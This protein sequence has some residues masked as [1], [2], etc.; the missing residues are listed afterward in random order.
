MGEIG[1]K[2]GL[3]QVKFREIPLC[4]IKK[5]SLPFL[6]C[7]DSIFSGMK[8]KHVKITVPQLLWYENSQTEL[9][10]PASWSIAYC[11]MK[12]AERKRLTSAG[13]KNAFAHPIGSDP[14]RMLA[15]GKREI[16]IIFDDLARPTPVSEIAP[17]LLMELE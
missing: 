10:F 11:P 4:L 7:L 17:F 16:A 6:F 3:K 15:R 8:E 13:M 1:G 12:G 2:V 9:H 5:L 14:I